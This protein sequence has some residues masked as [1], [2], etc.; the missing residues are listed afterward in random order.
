[1]SPV[2]RTHLCRNNYFFSCEHKKY[3]RDPWVKMEKELGISKMQIQKTMQTKKEFMSLLHQ[4]Y[5]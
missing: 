1:M 5:T 3:A 2:W 4:H